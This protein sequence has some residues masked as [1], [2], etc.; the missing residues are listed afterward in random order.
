MLIGDKPGEPKPEKG[1]DQGYVVKTSGGISMTA[2]RDVDAQRREHVKCGA[3]EQMSIHGPPGAF[4][5]EPK[6]CQPHDNDHVLN[7]R[8]DVVIEVVL[9]LGRHG[10]HPG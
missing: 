5:S 2:N 10:V 4:G 9:P 1:R 6:P 3:A 7:V 8:Y